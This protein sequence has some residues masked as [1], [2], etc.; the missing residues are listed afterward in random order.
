MLIV[1]NVGD[2]PDVRNCMHQAVTCHWFHTTYSS[3]ISKWRLEAEVSLFSWLEYS[4]SNSL[5]L[6]GPASII[7]LIVKQAKGVG[8]AISV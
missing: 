5:F 6:L 2:A 3:I 4:L 1:G 8:I 7:V